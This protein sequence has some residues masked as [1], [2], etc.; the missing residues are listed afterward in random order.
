MY[1]LKFYPIYFEKIWGGRDLKELKNDLPAGIIGESWEISCH[2]NGSSIILNGIYKGLTLKELIESYK[3]KILGKNGSLEFPLLLK[4][5][6]SKE[7]LSIQVH[8]GDS[9][10]K[11]KENDNGKTEAWYVISAQEESNLVLGT[12]NCT[13]EEFIKAIKHGE[14]DRCLNTVKVKAGDIFYIESGLIHAIGPNVL[15]FEVQQSSDIT[16]RVYDYNRGR[17]LQLEKALE[18]IDFNLQSPKLEGSV[19]ENKYYKKV[20]FIS[21]KYF[22]LEECRVFSELDEDTENERFLLYTCLEGQGKIVYSQGEELII[23][24]ES[25]LIPSSLGQF[26][27]KGELKLIKTYVP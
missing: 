26:K 22:N 18:V 3:D 24:G 25:V 10:A 17:E 20:K 15:L 14:V 2:K 6:S 8:P 5:I 12:K 27:I 16:Y 4:F 23:K 19:E 11:L 9:Y 1:P 21:C 13:K 7:S